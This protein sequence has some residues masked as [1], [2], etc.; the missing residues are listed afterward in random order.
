MG[1]AVDSCPVVS[2]GASAQSLC[3]LS[4]SVGGGAGGEQP[5][6][7][8]PMLWV[9]VMRR[10][11]RV[12]QLGPE[13]EPD[14]HTSARAWSHAH[15]THVPLWEAEPEGHLHR[16]DAVIQAPAHGG[17]HGPLVALFTLPLGF[18]GFFVPGFP[19]AL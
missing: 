17:R 18:S 7:L 9:T 15:S 19:K 6:L 16:G 4:T 2:P 3:T 1:R 12:G 14:A 8:H 13:E 5:H 11:C 10:V